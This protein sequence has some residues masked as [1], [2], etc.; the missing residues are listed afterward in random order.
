[1]L[2]TSVE[3]VTNRSKNSTASIAAYGS[4]EE[5]GISADFYATDF[6]IEN[7]ASIN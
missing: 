2:S 6:E 7:F 3:P 1:M 4:L 5:N